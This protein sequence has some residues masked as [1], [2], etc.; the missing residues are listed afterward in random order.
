MNTCRSGIV[1]PRTTLDR[2]IIKGVVPFSSLLMIFLGF[3]IQ[4]EI[5]APKFRQKLEL[6]IIVRLLGS[7]GGVV[8]AFFNTCSNLQ[9]CTNLRPC[10]NYLKVIKPHLWTIITLQSF[11]VPWRTAH[12]VKLWMLAKNITFARHG[13][14]M[15]SL[16]A[17]GTALL[18]GESSRGAGILLWHWSSSCPSFWSE[19]LC[20][21]VPFTNSHSPA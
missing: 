5:Q 19:L 10:G 7:E 18:W 13:L 21:A 17:P 4:A 1:F 9:N 2:Y 3:I 11:A 6:F 20:R 15:G 8:K 12:S 14:P 16:L